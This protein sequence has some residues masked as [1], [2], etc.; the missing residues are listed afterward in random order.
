ML[1]NENCNRSKG[2]N[3]ILLLFILL[4]RVRKT[5]IFFM[6]QKQMMVDSSVDR[7]AIIK[8]SNLHELTGVSN[9]FCMEYKFDVALRNSILN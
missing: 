1:L 4:K 7:K 6:P 9:I 8:L 5:E 2:L 3:F